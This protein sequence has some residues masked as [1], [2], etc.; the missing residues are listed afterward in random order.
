[1]SIVDVHNELNE[2]YDR[3]VCI[4][5]EQRQRLEAARDACLD[6]LSRGIEELGDDRGQ[7][8][9]T[10]ASFIEQGSFAMDTLNQH[11]DNESDI[12]IAVIFRK[13]DLPTTALAARKRVA[14]ALVF[15]GGGF[16]RSPEART[17]AV[18][19][20]YADGAHVDFAIYR[21][22]GTTLE[23]AGPN[24]QALDPTAV[25]DWFDSKVEALSPEFFTTV[26]KHQFRRI[27]RWVKMFARS[28]RKW[29]LPGG[30]I[31]SA[32]L[33][34]TYQL[35][36]KRDDIALYTTLHATLERLQN[37]LAVRS[38]VN[39]SDLTRKPTR[40]AQMKDL[41]AVLH[42]ALEDLAVV[43][44]PNCSRKKA[45]RAWAT[46]FNHDFWREAA[47]DEPPQQRA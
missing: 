1:V 22:S 14:D 47:I 20:W 29:D 42:D 44:K 41:E 36:R 43:S 39:S 19:V 30:M 21:Q 13:E 25:K 31:L 28:R 15:A 46:F 9:Q 35:H 26:R 4:G 6:R 38:P 18:T 45:L 17:N 8:F 33:A 27:V 11:R 2:F 3:F 40:L 23:H 32:L 7:T 10:F 34:E 12:D 16:A 37:S 24:W 5:K